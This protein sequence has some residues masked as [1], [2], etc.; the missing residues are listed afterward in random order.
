VQARRLLRTY[1]LFALWAATSHAGYTHYWKWLKAPAPA[2]L[3]STLV[4]M[5][6]VV[7]A[8]ADLVEV[9]IDLDPAMWPD[10]SASLPTFGFNGRGKDAY[11]TF[12]FPLAPF[13]AENPDFQ[14]VK[15][16]WRPYDEV[17][18]ACLIVAGEHF[19]HD[20]LEISSDG[21]WTR[22][23]AKGR[24]LFEEVFNRPAVTVLA[25]EKADPFAAL[26]EAE[27]EAFRKEALKEL[28]RLKQPQSGESATSEGMRRNLAVSGA[29]FML[30]VAVL[31]FL[32]RKP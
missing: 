1:L 11:E 24:K 16:Q 21:D 20:V 9:A 17:V 2:A 13:T 27:R 31:Y 29:F 5:R 8:R 25:H 23:W 6:R 18:V 15:T 22:E 32:S 7:Q 12:A 3:E 28:R 4:D 26:S 19:S 10:A 30:L 14:L